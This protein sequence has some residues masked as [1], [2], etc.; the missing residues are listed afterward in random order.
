MIDSME[1]REMQTKVKN[2]LQFASTNRILLF[3][4]LRHLC[5]EKGNDKGNSS[6]NGSK[7]SITN[8]EIDLP[9]LH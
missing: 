2:L 6:E 3:V 4:V 7:C 5:V 9:Y 1:F 8:Y